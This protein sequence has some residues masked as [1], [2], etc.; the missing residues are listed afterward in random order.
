MVMGNWDVLSIQVLLSA[1]LQ[2]HSLCAKR[3]AIYIVSSLTL[4]LKRSEA[5]WF[6]QPA[7]GCL[8]TDSLL[9]CVKWVKLGYSTIRGENREPLKDVAQSHQVFFDA[10]IV[11]IKQAIS[12]VF[13]V[14]FVNWVH[15]T[16]S[17][18]KTYTLSVPFSFLL[19]RE[20]RGHL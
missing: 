14:H 19:I 12:T 8:H 4:K 2:P 17:V 11:W 7:A 15:G 18:M 3:I 13:V 20:G 5:G 1:W 9:A 6:Q 16:F 10:E